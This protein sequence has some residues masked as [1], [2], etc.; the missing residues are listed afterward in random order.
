MQTGWKGKH[1]TEESKKKMSETKKK[2]P[3]RFWLGKKGLK[4]GKKHSEETKQKIREKLTG[5]KRTEETIKKMSFIM[6]GKYVGKENHFFGRKH[7]K[8]TKEKMSEKARL[9][10]GEK[11]GGWIDGRNTKEHIVWV[12]N[13]RNRVIKRLK[14]E[15][16]AHTWGEWELLKKQYNF[17][18][19]CC[20]KSEPEIKLTEDHI[21]P[22]SKGGSDLIENI[23]PMCLKCN[24][25]KHTKIIKYV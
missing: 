15:S 22:L 21:I 11:A 3:V 18:C 9:R 8:E 6:K 13:K 17:T 7:T 23:Q 2:N 14:I 20:K 5:K 12:K 24:L 4:K 1:H 19:P 10:K 16:L 25:K